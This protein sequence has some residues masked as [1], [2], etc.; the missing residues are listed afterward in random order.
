MYINW[1]KGKWLFGHML[2]NYL[3]Y[4]ILQFQTKGKHCHFK[5]N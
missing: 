2:Q 5:V 1:L 3:F 4:N